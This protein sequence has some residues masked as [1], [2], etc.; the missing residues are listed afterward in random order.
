MKESEQGYQPK[1]DNTFSHPPTETGTFFNK[2][3]MS[4]LK[5]KPINKEAEEIAE[6]LIK[7]HNDIYVQ[8]DKVII[9]HAIINCEDII[10]TA[11]L[12]N[13]GMYES[14]SGNEFINTHKEALI[15]LKSK[16]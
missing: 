12:F 10:K 9:K 4:S 14:M 8:A 11:Y 2:N 15:I 16:I 7:R 6:N 13:V 1:I 5:P 3:N